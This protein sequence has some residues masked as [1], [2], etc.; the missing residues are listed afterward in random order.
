MDRFTRWQEAIPM[1]GIQAEAV[2]KTFAT[3]WVLA[4]GTQTTIATDRGRQFESDLFAQPS[5]LS[6]TKRIHKCAYYLQA[7]GL[8]GRFHCQL[9][10]C[11]W[12]QRNPN[13][14]TDNFPLVQLNF[15]TMIKVETDCRPAE[16]V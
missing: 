12:C 7:N 8:V 9:K 13:K 6:G 4:F 5:T 2:A 1:P 16:I 3:H 14:Y 10:A 11:L 15:R